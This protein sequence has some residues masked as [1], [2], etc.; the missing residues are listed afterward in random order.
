MEFGLGRFGDRR[1]EKGGPFFWPVLLH[2]VAAS[3]GCASWVG[4][5]LGRFA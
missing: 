1:L 5:G 2:W 3:Y 4:A